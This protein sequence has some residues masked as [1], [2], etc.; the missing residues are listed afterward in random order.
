M[1]RGNDCAVR[2]YTA[3]FKT[4]VEE[5]MWIEESHGSVRFCRVTSS[6]SSRVLRVSREAKASS[7]KESIQWLFIDSHET[8]WLQHFCYA[9]ITPLPLYYDHT[10]AA[11]LLLHHC[12]HTMTTPLL[13]YNDYTTAAVLWTACRTDTTLSEF[14]TLLNH[15]A[16][17]F[18]NPSYR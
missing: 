8:L 2:L 3:N 13:L 11:I 15:A 7:E 17:T 6:F 5:L 9:M 1:K 4:H 18:I 16:D 10:T 14:A 12:Y